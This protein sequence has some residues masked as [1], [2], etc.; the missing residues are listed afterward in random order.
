MKRI[1]IL[2][3]A[4]TTVAHAESID[5]ADSRISYVGRWDVSAASRPW[6]A[7][8]GSSCTV[9]FDGTAL[10]AEIESDRVEYVRVVIDKD[11]APNW[12]PPDLAGVSEND[13][14][15]YFQPAAGEPDFG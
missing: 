9:W 14:D 4:V 5:P 3:A 1:V 12:N 13:V 8:Q 10:K 6:C 15:E 2:L 11:G 7:W